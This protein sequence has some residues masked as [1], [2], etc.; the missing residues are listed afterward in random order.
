MQ[1]IEDRTNQLE[2]CIVGLGPHVEDPQGNVPVEPDRAVV[3]LPQVEIEG[4]ADDDRA[5]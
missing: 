3:G 2:I 4:V 1:P 5:V